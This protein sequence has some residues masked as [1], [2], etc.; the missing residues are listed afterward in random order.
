MAPYVF[1]VDG[2]RYIDLIGSWGPLILGHAHP[3]ILDAIARDDGAGHHVRRADRGRGQVRRGA[4]STPCRRWRWC[5]RCRRAPRRRCP[6]CGSRAASPVATKIIKADGGYHGHAD[7]LLVAAGSGAATLG[8]PGSAG[9]PEGAARDTIVVAVQRSRRGRRRRCGARRHRRDH[10]RAGRRQH[11]PRRAG[12]RLPRGSA[13]RSREARH[14][15]DLRRGDDRLPRRVRRRAGALQHH[16][17]PHDDRQ[18]HRRGSPGRGVRRPRRHHAEARAARPGLS[19]RDAQREI[20]SRWRPASRRWRS[21]AAPGPTTGSSTSASDSAMA[22]SRPRQAAEGPGRDEPGRLDADPVLQPGPGH[23]LRRLRRPRTPRGSGR[24]SAR[25]GIAACFCRPSQFEAMFVSP[26]AHRRG[27]RPDRRRARGSLRR[28][29]AVS[30]RGKWAPVMQSAPSNRGEM[31]QDSTDVRPLHPSVVT[32]RARLDPAARK[33]KG[34]A[35]RGAVAPARSASSSASPSIIGLLV[36]LLA[37]RQLGTAPWL[38]LVFLVFGLI[39][40]FRGVMRAVD[41]S[42]RSAGRH[43]GRGAQ[44][45]G[46]ARASSRIERLNYAARGDRRGRVA[47]I[48]PRTKPIVARRPRRRGSDL[49]ELLR[50]RAGSS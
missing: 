21:S 7:C 4:A 10:H 11:G 26:R 27:H 32:G 15:A 39:A 3:E 45:R 48:T 13:R 28:L 43:G 34:R 36:R 29:T 49:S 37:R 18:D 8:I 40:G 2:N 1:D 35:L 19:G 6:R 31:S 20:R 9:V 22:C 16:A 23:R 25:C 24:S 30:R 41:R 5:A 17:R 14:A 38:M 47:L 46:L 50:P 33:G 44:R 42:D 12:A